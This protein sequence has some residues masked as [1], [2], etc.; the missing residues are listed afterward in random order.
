MTEKELRTEPVFPRAKYTVFTPQHGSHSHRLSKPASLPVSSA[1]SP[2]GRTTEDTGIRGWATLKGC[3]YLQSSSGL[4]EFR[5][6][7]CCYKED[8]KWEK[9]DLRR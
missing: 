1:P 4:G 2:H 5:I 9:M 7:S 6:S 3:L 8:N